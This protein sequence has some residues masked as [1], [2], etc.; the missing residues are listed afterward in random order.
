MNTTLNIMWFEDNDEWYTA[1]KEDI[2]DYIRQH[3]F[4][5]N[6]V[7][8]KRSTIKDHDL[9]KFTY[10]IIFVDFKLLDDT[11]G[12]SAIQTIRRNNILADILFYSN[13]RDQIIEAMKENVLE[14]VYTSPRDDI[15][16]PARVKE[17]IDKNIRRSEDILNVRGM[18]MDHV[19]EFDEKLK[20]VIDKYYKEKNGTDKISV[21]DQYAFQKVV[22]Q[23]EDNIKKCTEFNEEGFLLNA[24]GKSF[25]IDS[26][27][28][29]LIVNEIFKLDYQQ[30]HEM[31]GFHEVYN[32]KILVERNKLA[33]ANKESNEDG[34]FYFEDKSGKTIYN[35]EKC[36]EIRSELNKYDTLLTKI[37]EYI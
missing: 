4:V 35:C 28:L 7:R 19:S 21:I 11:K 17:L 33:H 25:F 5:P 15:V 14:G 20:R 29:S 1:M 13:D 10:D 22:K 36:E 2:D 23:Y 24:L 16:F 27:K 8:E 34:Y 9:L 12:T 37:V 6:F 18:L 32:Q 3:C 31:R 26:Y 30:Y